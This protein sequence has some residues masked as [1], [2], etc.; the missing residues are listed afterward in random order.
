ME[1]YDIKVDCEILGV[2]FENIDKITVSQV[3][4]TYRKTALKVHPDK[5]DEKNKE[6]AKEDFQQLA[7]SYER[8]LRYVV[9]RVDTEEEK[10]EQDE[11]SV[12]KVPEDQRFTKD[13]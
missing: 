3:I 10:E 8:V 12:D 5:V 9:N 6:K 1:D 11:H 4:S 7:H 2:D 13:N